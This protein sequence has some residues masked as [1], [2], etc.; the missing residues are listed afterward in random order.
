MSNLVA[1]NPPVRTSGKRKRMPGT[2]KN[3]NEECKKCQMF[4]GTN[5]LE[6][7][8]DLFQFTNQAGLFGNTTDI[9][10]TIPVRGSWIPVPVVHPT[11]G[12]Y[13][14][15]RV[16][17]SYFIKYFRMKG[18]CLVK[19]NMIRPA[20]WR[21]RLIRVEDEGVFTEPSSSVSSHKVINSYLSAM[22]RNPQI[23]TGNEGP[24][25]RSKKLA[26]NYYCALKTRLEDMTIHSKIIASGTISSINVPQ[27]F[28]F[29][30]GVHSEEEPAGTGLVSNDLGLDNEEWAYSK[31]DVRVLVNDCVS[32]KLYKKDDG[33]NYLISDVDYY[34]VLETDMTYG[35]DIT[36]PNIG[37]GVAPAGTVLNSTSLIDEVF[38]LRM[39]QIQYFTDP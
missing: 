34:V 23:L 12:A 38:N 14:Y 18:Y 11:Q 31:F 4:A 1:F 33:N 16:G 13:G 37:G 6:K 32:Y 3:G 29:L 21:L 27:K 28:G 8:Y 36:Q 17:Q 35:Y 20:H 10:L 19:A 2:N 15:N 9:G 22:Y 5:S 24:Q 26:T 25:D 39:T 7:I 30:P